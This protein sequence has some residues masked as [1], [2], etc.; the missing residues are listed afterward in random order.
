MFFRESDREDSPVIDL[1]PSVEDEDEDGVDPE[2]LLKGSYYGLPILKW[3]LHE[4]FTFCYWCAFSR[5]FTPDY[6]IYPPYTFTLTE[7]VFGDPD[8]YNISQK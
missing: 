1:P 5:E 3:V 7:T 6:G 2:P 8:K 4:M